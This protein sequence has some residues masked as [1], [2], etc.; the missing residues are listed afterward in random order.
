MMAFLMRGGCH[1]V[2]IIGGYISP[3][4]TGYFQVFHFDFRN[5]HESFNFY[6]LLRFLTPKFKKI[7]FIDGLIIQPPTKPP[8]FKSEVHFSLG[9]IIFHDF[10]P[11]LINENDRLLIESL[12]HILPI[13]SIEGIKS[14]KRLLFGFFFYSV[15][16]IILIMI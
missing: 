10:P 14:I 16:Y 1:Y 7:F 5:L 4:N 13:L 11:I 8:M 15:I 9:F 6:L 12:Y 3:T 2:L